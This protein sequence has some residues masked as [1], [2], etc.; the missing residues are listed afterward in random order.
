MFIFPSL[1]LFLPSQPSL[2]ARLSSRFELCSV[3]VS[4]SLSCRLACRCK[5]TLFQRCSD[6]CLP[7]CCVWLLHEI[8]PEPPAVMCP[9]ATRPY[10]VRRL[11][12]VRRVCTEA[13]FYVRGVIVPSSLSYVI[14]SLACG[15][16]RQR[17]TRVTDPVA[18]WNTAFLPSLTGSSSR[19]A[20]R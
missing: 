4:C 18:S 19:T 13:V 17:N 16:I 8:F 20:V 1:S 3:Y 10:N 2:P 11:L 7:S 14:H 12:P 6:L 5:K 15:I 9:A